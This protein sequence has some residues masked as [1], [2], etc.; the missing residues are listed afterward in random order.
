MGCII[1]DILKGGV[2]IKI[3]EI[4]KEKGLSQEQLS[5]MSGV[6]RVTIARLE[7]GCSSPK[8]PTLKAIAD[9]LGVSIDDLIDR[10]AG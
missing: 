9:A 2:G 6:S 4:R 1:Y 5:E 10:E 3:A 8:L 7:T